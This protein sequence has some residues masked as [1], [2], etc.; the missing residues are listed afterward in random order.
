MQLERDLDQRIQ[1]NFYTNES[2]F[3]IPGEVF[4][5]L[6]DNKVLVE[7]RFQEIPF[8]DDRNISFRDVLVFLNIG[9][10][11]ESII[12]MIDDTENINNILDLP[13]LQRPNTFQCNIYQNRNIFNRNN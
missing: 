3:G 8:S 12:E 4:W 2:E 11:D 10:S 1:F 13:I 5:N 7:Y 6:T 9:F